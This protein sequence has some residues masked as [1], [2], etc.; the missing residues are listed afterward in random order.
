MT[1]KLERQLAAAVQADQ[2]VLVSCLSCI[3]TPAARYI[4][5]RQ[6]YDN[7]TP[8]DD[9]LFDRKSLFKGDT[10]IQSSSLLMPREFFNSIKFPLLRRHEDWDFVLRAVKVGQARIV[11]VPETL[12]MIYLEEDR[13]S[14]STQHNWREAIAWLD[15]NRAYIGRRAYSG[16]CLTIAMPEAAVEKDYSAFL[17]GLWRAFRYG[18]PRLTHIA[19]YLTFWLVPAR[20]RRELRAIVRGS[21]IR[22]RLLDGAKSSGQ[23]D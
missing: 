12:V 23:I 2:P 10:Y 1:Q 22:D 4:W 8:I 9:Y 21:T 17:L 14:L 16:F 11:T 19:F 18:S 7:V 13:E 15:S 5:P 20:W 3:V 6:I